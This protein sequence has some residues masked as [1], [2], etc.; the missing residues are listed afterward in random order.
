MEK[1]LP[2]RLQSGGQRALLLALS[3]AAC[4]PTDEPATA[5]SNTQAAAIPG[6]ALRVGTDSITIERVLQLGQLDGP[7]EYAFGSWISVAPAADGSFYVCD[8]VDVTIRLYDATGVFVRAVGRQGAGPGEYRDCM[9]MVVAADGTLSV[10]DAANGRIARFAGDGV[11]LP[12]IP[13]V[14]A[15]GLGGDDTFRLDA[16]GQY[17]RRAQGAAPGA[18]ERDHPAYWVLIDSLG[19]QVDSVHV[20]T[21]GGSAGRGFG[22]STSEGMYLAQPADSVHALGADGTIAL[23]S[24]ARYH[25]LLVQPDSAR[26]EITRE[27]DALAFEPAELAEWNA[28]RDFFASMS[29]QFPPAPMRDRKPVLRGLRMDDLGRL[30]V[31]VHVRAEQ[32]PIP[33]RPAGDPRPLLTWRERNTY[34][35]FDGRSGAFIGRVAFPYDTQLLASQGDLVW[36]REEGESGELLIGVY[37]LVAAGK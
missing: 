13:A 30:W 35:L 14:T 21:P 26:P 1:S 11:A 2:A 37:R 5:S 10:S 17:W 27:L 36:L 32:R 16:R 12:M 6:S 31:H 4:A 3:L 28:W 8:A 34:D 19:R 29:S 23:A 25:V 9:P 7:P 24:P 15:G 18:Q 33:P 20:P 22:L